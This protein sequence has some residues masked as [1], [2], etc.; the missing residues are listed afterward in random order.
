MAMA[1]AGGRTRRARP[2]QGFAADQHTLPPPPHAAP[3]PRCASA[4]AAARRHAAPGPVLLVLC[5][6]LPPAHSAQGSAADFAAG[7]QGTTLCPRFASA[8]ASCQ[9]RRDQADG[10][11]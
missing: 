9:G 1:M 7:P 8:A 6:P 4:A 3:S 10:E 5:R 11:R 2:A